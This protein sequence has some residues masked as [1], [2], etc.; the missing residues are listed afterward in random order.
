MLVVLVV[1]EVVHPRHDGIAVR[2]VGGVVPVVALVGK[3]AGTLHRAKCRERWQELAELTG[4]A[5]FPT[6]W[7]IPVPIAET[8][9]AWVFGVVVAVI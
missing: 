1:V 6:R 8:D 9:A 4:A 7:I 3:Q 5:E 2:H